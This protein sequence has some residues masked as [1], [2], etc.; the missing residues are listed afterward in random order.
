MPHNDPQSTV[1]QPFQAPFGAHSRKRQE[2]VYLDDPATSFWLKRQIIETRDRDPLDALS[3]AQ[4]LV[5]ILSTR[6]HSLA[7]DAA[8]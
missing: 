7:R 5:D 2:K 6:V 4:L 1:T 8:D 3:D